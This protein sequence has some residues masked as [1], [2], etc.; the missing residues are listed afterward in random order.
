MNLLVTKIFNNS[1]GYKVKEIL[2]WLGNNGFDKAMSTA[3]LDRGVKEGII[4]KSFKD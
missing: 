1:R 3:A 2:W 4:V